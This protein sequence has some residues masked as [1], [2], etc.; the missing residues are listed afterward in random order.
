MH[1]FSSY[2]ETNTENVPHTCTH[3]T[4]KAEVDGLHEC[5]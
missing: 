5:K 2:D 3:N 1:Y 4:L